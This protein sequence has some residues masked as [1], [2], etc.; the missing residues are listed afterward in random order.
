MSYIFLIIA[1]AI[2]D[3][4]EWSV[5]SKATLIVKRWHNKI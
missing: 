1:A 5:A 2:V 3:V 4:V